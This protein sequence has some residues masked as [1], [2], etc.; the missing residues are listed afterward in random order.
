MSKLRAL[1]LFSGIGAFEQA[2]FE[3]LFTKRDSDTVREIQLKWGV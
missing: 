3:Q 2:I 1:S